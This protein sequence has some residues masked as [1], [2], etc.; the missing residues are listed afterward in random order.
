[1]LDTPLR[2]LQGNLNRSIQATESFLELAIREK[3]DILVVQEPW[4][5]YKEEEG[6]TRSVAHPSFTMLKPKHSTHTRPRTLVYT[7]RTLTLQVTPTAI[8]DSDIQSLTIQDSKGVKL[9]IVN[10]YNERDTNLEWTIP[11]SLLGL[12]LLDDCLLLGD[13]NI[14]HPSWDLYGSDT[15]CRAQTFVE[16]LET[17]EFSLQN[18]PNV[19]TFYRPHLVHPSVLDLSFLRSKRIKGDLKWRTLETGSDHL[20]IC[21]DIPSTVN[22]QRKVIDK[23]LFNTKKANWES[24]QQYLVDNS[25]EIDT[26]TNDLDI[27]ASSF[28]NLI[29]N[30]CYECIPT[31]KTVPSS[32]AW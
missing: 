5:L 10:V 28:S 13:F 23:V 30:A 27:L 16:W 1:M 21:L 32:K 11:R 14:R 24:F 6:Y 22:S 15:S 2:V 3:A 9:Q 4:M 17:K 20:T 8:D 25:K 19:P 29:Q 26:S 31:R 7:R 12:P 18:I